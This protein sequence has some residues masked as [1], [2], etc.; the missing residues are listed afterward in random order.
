MKKRLLTLFLALCLVFGSVLPVAAD[1]SDEEMYGVLS[2][3]GI[4][5][6]D[7]NGDLNLSENVTRAQFAKMLT[8]ASIYGDKG[9]SETGV[10]PFSD[11]S[12]SHW[13]AGYV[14]TARDAGWINGYLDAT[15][16]P[17]EYV[18]LGEALTSTLKLLGYSD[19]DFSGTW[20][21]GQVA[22]AKNISLS[23]GV[24]AGNYDAL[25]RAECARIIY[26]ALNCNTKSGT[27]QALAIGYTLDASGNIDYLALMNSSMDGPI[28]AIG[29]A[30][31]TSIG[32][33]PLHVYRNGSA[34]QMSS[35]ANYDLVYYS[36]KML[37][38]WAWSNPKTGTI[39][40]I[41]PNTS[42]PTSVT[43]SGATYSLASSVAAT[44]VSNLGQFEVGDAVTALLG[45]EGTIEAIYSISDIET[46]VM[47]VVTDAGT[48]SYTSASG[49]SYTQGF[50]SLIASDGTVMQFGLST[51]PSSDAGDVIAISVTDGK[52]SIKSASSGG[53]SGTVDASER[54]IGA[55][56]VADNVEILDVS[57]SYGKTIALSRL[58]GVKISTAD[59]LGKAFNSSGDIEK[60]ILDNV[61]GDADSYGILSD[62]STI[63]TSSIAFYEYYEYIVNGVSYEYYSENRDF[64]GSTGPVCIAG[65]VYAPEKMSALESATITELGIATA[66]LGGETFDLSSVQV[67]E[68]RGTDY[69]L[70][71]ISE[72]NTSDYA[73]KGYYDSEPDEGG[74]L[75]IIIATAK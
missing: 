17:D 13:A 47:G 54:T 7:E 58:D 49:D 39:D 23:T 22:L 19:D 64:G 71:P 45:R 63:M 28:V 70:K 43:I 2:A 51:A 62:K 57:E 16:R 37:T 66:V 24:N 73:L 5:N 35:V 34:A 21:S 9:G 27:V 20:P 72:I 29:S 60:L 44:A 36:E 46:S 40:A 12:Y 15:F 3:L 75:R 53:V 69:Y 32:F 61:T 11:V 14:A 56:S 31:E 68:R 41:L 1:S 74:K 4:M 33:T 26:N 38:I 25:T 18:T 59:V 67:Y 52:T 8:G 50:V 55:Y 42:N 30:W 10:S 6:G 65:D 48:T